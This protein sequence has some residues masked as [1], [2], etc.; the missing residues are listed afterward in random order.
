[1]KKTILLL[2]C[3]STGSIFAQSVKSGST[4]QLLG[5]RSWIR[6]NLPVQKDTSSKLYWSTENKKPASPNATINNNEAFYI[7]NVKPETLYYI[8]AE[9]SQG[10]QKQTVRTSKKWTL[11]TSELKELNT[12]PSS[13]AIPQGMK[14]FW[15]D[16]FNDKL[17]NKN[18]W[19]TNYFS[20]LNYTSEESKKEMLAGQLPQPAY[21]LNG[22]FINLYIS[23]T[24]PKRSYNLKGGQKISS[25]Q[26]YD[27]KSN[28]N[29]LDNSRGGYFEVKVRRN[30]SGNPEGTNTA[31][32]FDSPGPDLRYYLEQGTNLN[33]TEGIRPKGQLFEIDVFEYLNAQFV[34]HGHVDQKG[35]FQ[36]NLATHIAEGIDHINKWVTHG[37]LWTPT[38]I[39]HYINGKLIKDYT[40]KHQIYSPNHFMNVFLGSYGAKGQ[41]NMDVDYIRAYNWPLEKGNELPN[42]GFED[43]GSLIPWEG[44]GTLVPQ[45]GIKNSTAALLNPGE[46]IEQYV[47]LNHSTSYQ[48]ELFIKNKGN[49]KVDIDDTA[50]VSGTLSSIKKS[51]F[52]GNG[53]YAKQHIDFIT[54]KDKAYNMKTIRISI[55]N[56]GNSAVLLDD[57]TIKKIK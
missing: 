29:L 24:L 5:T 51:E 7:Q 39:K 56:T 45:K 37:I 13:E 54:G 43:S 30:S 25:I 21:T 19:S 28:E 49:I 34:L 2:L 44:N 11:D 20:S 4:L 48:L 53:N 26:T 3:F 46:N 12:N 8:W 6:V 10:L 33:G 31:F 40:D 57:I 32:W 41:V 16:E 9:T 23:D 55:K 22:K 18:K 52:T 50:P 42:P 17:L 27:W 35:V 1:M 36:R 15:Q 14:I 38:S 47:Y